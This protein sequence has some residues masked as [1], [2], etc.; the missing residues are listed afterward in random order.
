LIA[1]FPNGEVFHLNDARGHLRDSARALNPEVHPINFAD[2][3]LTHDAELQL[4]QHFPGADSV[5]FLPLWDW[6]KAQWLAGTF[7]W[8]QNRERA[9]ELEE[10]HYFKIFS[11]SITSEVARVNWAQNEQ[12]KSTFLSSISHELRS[13]LHG[14][15]ASAE[16]L[17]S[18]SLRTDQ[19]ELIGM[20]K[21]CGT[22]LLDTMNHLWVQRPLS[23]LWG[24]LI[25]SLQI[26]FH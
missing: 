2:Q 14:I 12:S 22:T 23:M 7:L 9:L 20:L 25:N 17:S 5:I 18:T 16:L 10:L 11:D 26:G 19:Q 3:A 4:L 1:S 6:D 24:L 8:T 15:L 13:P 21:T